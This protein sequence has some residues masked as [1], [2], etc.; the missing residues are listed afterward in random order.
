VTWGGFRRHRGSLAGY[1]E[2]GSGCRY[3]VSMR[4]VNLKEA[5]AD[6][7]DLVD[8]A[9]AG[10]EVVISR[11][12]TPLVRLMPVAPAR[13]ERRFGIDQGKFVVPDDFDAPDPEI[14]RLFYRTEDD[15][16]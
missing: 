16:T 2:F 12:G 5:Q 1:L 15:P 6:L 14:E 13:R 11:E 8:E 10:E 9:L 7:A 3:G 4:K